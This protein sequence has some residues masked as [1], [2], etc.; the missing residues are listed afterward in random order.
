M[1][2]MER[3]EGFIGFTSAT[4]RTGR[5]NRFAE[6][7]EMLRLTT[8]CARSG[9]DTVTVAVVRSAAGGKTTVKL[10][11]DTTPPRMPM[12]L[13]LVVV[14]PPPPR[15]LRPRTSAGAS[16]VPVAIALDP[17]SSAVGGFVGRSDNPATACGRAK[18]R[19]SFGG[20]RDR[21]GSMRFSFGGAPPGSWAGGE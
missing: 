18:L 8:G 9:C 12:V 14:E 16:L 20:R 10:P 6:A 13:V 17:S 1:V 3:S 2:A 4:R 15:R 11:T 7:G 5:R 21:R 19:G